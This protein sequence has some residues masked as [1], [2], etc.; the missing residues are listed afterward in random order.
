MQSTKNQKFTLKVKIILSSCW[1]LVKFIHFS[2]AIS[3]RPCWT[4]GKS[5]KTMLS[6]G[7]KNFILCSFRP[8]NMEKGQGKREDERV[9]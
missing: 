3:Q 6:V 2:Q 8:A 5:W 9:K 7:A 1:P 4:G